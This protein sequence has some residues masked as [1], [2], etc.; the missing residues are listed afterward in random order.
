MSPPSVAVHLCT[1]FKCSSLFFVS[2][3][4]DFETLHFLVDFFFF[5]TRSPLDLLTCVWTILWL[6]PLPA[7]LH[8]SMFLNRYNQTTDCSSFLPSFL[9]SFYCFAY[10]S[11][12]F[13]IGCTSP[14]QSIHCLHKPLQSV[15][16][17]KLAV[18]RMAVTFSYDNHYICL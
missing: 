14:Q 10:T 8:K 7:S 9:P 15:I 18:M 6:L 2:P 3:A 11:S 12:V 17:S 16:V 13:D 5:F 1:L 4:G